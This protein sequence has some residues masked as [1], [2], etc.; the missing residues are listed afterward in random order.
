MIPRTRRFAPCLATLALLLALASGAR[1][2]SATGDPAAAARAI[3]RLHETLLGVMKEAD[4]LGYAGRLGRIAPV[5][6]GLYDFPFM[7]EKSV[8][9]GW[10]QLDAAQRA[11]L[12]DAFGRLA[13]ATY[14][15]RFDGFEGERFE[16][17]GT[18]P[19]SHQTLLVKTRIVRGN[20]EVVPLD[21]RMRAGSG[22]WRIVDVFMDGTVSELALRRSEYSSV[23]RREGFDALL[24]ALEEKIAAQAH[25]A[26]SAAS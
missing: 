10:Q 25:G 4:A 16:T 13:A 5:L 11:K 2:E 3:D 18:E 21:Y 6:D 15:A 20:G 7:A 1:A 26:G 8:G 17:L 12:I 19:A 9:L 23:L 14:A 24:A 22:G